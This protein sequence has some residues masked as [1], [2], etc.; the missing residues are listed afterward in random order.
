MG[1]VEKESSCVPNSL[2]TTHENKFQM[3]QMCI[4]FLKNIKIPE[5]NIRE[6]LFP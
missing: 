2:H 1:H 5:E 3:D 4:D 6:Y